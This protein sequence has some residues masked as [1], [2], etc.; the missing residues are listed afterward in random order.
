MVFTIYGGWRS[1]WSCDLDFAIKLSLLLPMDVE[2]KF[3]FDW[4]SD[5]TE[6]LCKV[7]MDDRQAKV[8]R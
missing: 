4:P 2:I 6:D 5:F 1:S 8:K 3:H 7:C